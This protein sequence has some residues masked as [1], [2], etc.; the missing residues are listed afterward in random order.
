VRP[1]ID[2]LL[3]TRKHGPL[4]YKLHACKSDIITADNNGFSFSRT[5]RTEHSSRVCYHFSFVFGGPGFSSCLGDWLYLLRGFAVF[6]TPSRQIRGLFLYMATTTSFF[7]NSN[8]LFIE[9][10]TFLHHRTLSLNVPSLT[11]ISLIR[12]FISVSLGASISHPWPL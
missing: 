6:L 8:S 2:G 3:E 5:Q 11:T 10:P 9:H 12:G 1:T 7:L 4:P